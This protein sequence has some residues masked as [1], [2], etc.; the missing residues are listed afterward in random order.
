MDPKEKLKALDAERA[1]LLQKANDKPGEFTTEDGERATTLAKD[2]S[3]TKE[4]IAKQAEAVA[5]LRAAGMGT[6]VE[7]QDDLPGAPTGGTIGERFMQS[8]AMKAF[9]A[10]NPISV[11]KGQAIHIDSGPLEGFAITKANPLNT[12]QPGLSKPVR[13]GQIDDL[14]YRPRRTFLDLITG[15]KTKLPWFEYRR[16]IAVENNASIVGE[17]LTT[18]GTTPKTGLAPISTL[19]TDLAEAKVYGYGDGMEV[20]VQELTDDGI[21]ASLIDS[22]LTENIYD[23]IERVVLNGDTALDEPAGLLKLTGVLQ[24]AFTTDVPTTIRKAITKLRT[25]SGARI[26]AVVL[27]PEDDETWDLMKDLEERYLTG[28]PSGAGE[29]KAWGFERVD[30][31]ALEVGQAVMGDFSTIQLLVQGQLKI[32]AFNQ[33]KDYAQRGLAYIRGDIQALQVFRNVSKLLI[34]DLTE[35]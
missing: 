27:H 16:V 5:S 3:D 13:I 23:E 21:I 26:Q 19:T 34:A 18:T 12:V 4:L 30:S 6:G 28:G 10:A 7:K 32:Q 1:T 15:G 35:G 31:Q 25:T 2:I 33:H 29:K 14:V 17:S 22:T 8:D 11:A 24:Q 20:T 9:R